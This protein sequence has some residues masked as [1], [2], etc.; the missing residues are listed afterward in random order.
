M[1][2]RTVNGIIL[3]GCDKHNCIDNKCSHF[4]YIRKSNF[5]LQHDKYMVVGTWI[6]YCLVMAT[7]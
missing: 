7:K 2:E 4:L 5:S 6:S 3:N 1:N